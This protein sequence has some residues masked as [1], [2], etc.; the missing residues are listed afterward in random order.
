MIIKYF[1]KAV[2]HLSEYDLESIAR[3]LSK[4]KNPKIEWISRC[5]KRLYELGLEDIY[6]TINRDDVCLQVWVEL[7]KILREKY[8]Y[9]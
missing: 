5:D 8:N 3:E 9:K 2:F 7:E 4:S 6:Y 1:T